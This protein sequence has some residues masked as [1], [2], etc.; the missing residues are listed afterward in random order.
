MTDTTGYWDSISGGDLDFAWRR[1]HVF[2]KMGILKFIK[3]SIIIDRIVYQLS[4]D[5]GVF[6]SAKRVIDSLVENV[7]F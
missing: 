3:Y 6:N 7:T 2:V 5:G 1:S 4:P